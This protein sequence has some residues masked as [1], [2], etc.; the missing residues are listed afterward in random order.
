MPDSVAEAQPLRQFT[1]HLSSP[2]DT[3][4]MYIGE[5]IMQTE[6]GCILCDKI[7]NAKTQ[8]AEEL[9]WEFKET[10]GFLGPWQFYEGYCIVT[11][12]RHFTELYQPS[13]EQRHTIIDEVAHVAKAI[14]A[15]VKPRKINYEW[16]GNQVPHMHWHLFPRQQRDPN[17]LHAVWLDIAAAEKD[18]KKK[19]QW[20]HCARGRS[21]LLIALQHEVQQQMK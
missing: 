4:I 1:N 12:K 7:K 17:H 14:Q 20:Q 6:A 10:I 15:V 13:T 2:P 16:L 21:A 11:A 3:I 9:V 5:N 8:H 18:A 19:Q